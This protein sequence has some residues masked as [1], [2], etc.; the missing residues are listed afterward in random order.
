MVSKQLLETDRYG[1]GVEKAGGRH[2][3]GP[4]R[5]N[6]FGEV[7]GGDGRKLLASGISLTS[8]NHDYAAIAAA[9]ARLIAAAPDLLEIVRDIVSDC[10]GSINPGLHDLAVA[11]IAK[12]TTPEPSHD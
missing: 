4:W 12:A 3:P 7:I 9:N 5:I 6:E 11:T 8:G 1:A 10:K 2:T